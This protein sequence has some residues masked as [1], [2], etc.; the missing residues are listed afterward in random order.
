MCLYDIIMKSIEKI[1]AISIVKQNGS[2]PL[3]LAAERGHTEMV[4]ILLLH[5]A[6]VDVFDEV[7]VVLF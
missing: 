1:L 7:T 5:H 6:R 3:L 4:K 2:S